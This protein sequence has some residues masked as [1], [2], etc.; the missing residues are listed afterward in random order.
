MLR[1][2]LDIGILSWVPLL[3]NLR[4]MVL[5]LLWLLLEK[6]LLSALIVFRQQ[7]GSSLVLVHLTSKGVHMVSLVQTV[8][9]LME[10]LLLPVLLKDLEFANMLRSIG[11]VDYILLLLLYRWA[12]IVLLV[13]GG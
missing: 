9:V 8:A 12:P 13:M 6:L 1:T 11:S 2:Q 10:V 3:S 5:P 4:G 7:T